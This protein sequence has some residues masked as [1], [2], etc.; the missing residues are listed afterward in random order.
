[1]SNA[2]LEYELLITAAKAMATI[3]QVE[4][5]AA[6][7]GK[8][9]PGDPFAGMNASAARAV[10]QLA[11]LDAR[12]RQLGKGGLTDDPFARLAASMQRAE[13]L[14]G[15]LGGG[16]GRVRWEMEQAARGASSLAATVGRPAFSVLTSSAT[17]ADTAL[18]AVERRMIGLA[19]FS[20]TV[21]LGGV[22]VG[23]AGAAAGTGAALGA[24]QSYTAFSAQVR[25]ASEN[26][27]QFEDNLRS[28]YRLAQETRTPVNELARAF[29]VFQGV[30]VGLDLP[31]D[32][33]E[34]LTGIVARLTAADMGTTGDRGSVLA[35]L[36][37]FI[38]SM[39]SQ[40]LQAGELNS[41]ADQN[42]QLARAILRAAQGT[43]LQVSNLRGVAGEAQA[44]RL[45]YGQFLQSFLRQ[46]Q[47]ADTVFRASPVSI[48]SSLEPIRNSLR[49]FFGQL[50]EQAG[51]STSMAALARGISERLDSA[52]SGERAG[53]RLR[54]SVERIAT[55][56]GEAVDRVLDELAPLWDETAAAA[57]TTGQTIGTQLLNVGNNA[58]RAISKVRDLARETAALIERIERAATQSDEGGRSWL[59]YGAAGLL[60]RFAATRL[61]VAGG[62]LGVA[63]AVGGGIGLYGADRMEEGGFNLFDP[64][65]RTRAVNAVRGAVG[66]APMGEGAPNAPR[67]P[68]VGAPAPSGDAAGWRAAS[69][70]SWR[71]RQDDLARQRAAAAGVPANSGRV[72]PGEGGL[73]TASPG[74]SPDRFL[75]RLASRESGGRTGARNQ[76]G[77]S[78][79]YQF[80]AERLTDLGLYQRAPGENLRS[81]SW[82]GT[83]N[84]PGFEG[85]RTRADFLQNADAQMVAAIK[86]L[87]DIDRVIDSTPGA[88]RFS[89]DGLRAVAHLGGI[90]GMQ[91]Y[92]R[93]QGREVSD[94]LGTS[95]RDYYERFSALERTG[96]GVRE[97][98]VRQLEVAREQLR[99]AQANGGPALG[100]TNP[101]RGAMTQPP[102][103]ANIEN[104][105]AQMRLQAEMMG[106][107]VE[108]SPYLRRAEE[109]RNATRPAEIQAEERRQREI[110]ADEF[111]RSS[112]IG[113]NPQQV[114]PQQQ[115]ELREAQLALLEAQA[116][117]GVVGEGFSRFT[118]GFERVNEINKD[119]REMAAETARLNAA[120]EASPYLRQAEAERARTKPPEVLAEERRQR[121][122]QARDY[123]Q[124]IRRGREPGTVDPEQQE[125]VYQSRLAL[126]EAQARSETVQA[127]AGAAAR[128]FEESAN[129][130]RGYR[131]EQE[132]L[133]RLLQAYA[134]GPEAGRQ[135]LEDYQDER[136]VRDVARDLPEPQAAAVRE[137]GRRIGAQDRRREATEQA[138]GMSR[139]FSTDTSDM[140]RQIAA[141]GQGEE[142]VA[143]LNVQLDVERRSREVLRNLSGP[144]RE[145]LQGQIDDYVK[146]RLEM[147][148]T[149]AQTAEFR[150]AF[151]SAADNIGQSLYDMATG[152]KSAGDGFRELRSSMSQMVFQELA[153][154]PFRSVLGDVGARISGSLSSSE[155][156]GFGGIAGQLV[157]SV[158]GW[159]GFGGGATPRASGGPVDAGV[160]WVGEHGPEPVVFSGSG[161]VVSSQEAR[162]AVSGGGGGRGGYGGMVSI[163]IQTPNPTSFRDS[164]GQIAAEVARLVGRGQAYG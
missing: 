134:R 58:E 88:E 16:L 63:A 100:V 34:K 82:Q 36:R 114:N 71:M 53:Q 40:N 29:N 7:V 46:E 18:A 76:W 70:R 38:Q 90:G 83:F 45:D 81:N 41:I 127:R 77:Y 31:E 69:D 93:G 139:E 104:Q 111:E 28:V 32:V 84:I 6:G 23:A 112:R 65:G 74:S 164:Q 102:R 12:F 43:G 33:G 129:L 10:A 140:R 51:V 78:G 120:V 117:S 121:E 99:Q 89:R 97:G 133:E 24:A 143:R 91:S 62:P 148:R 146:L 49:R 122:V 15:P 149:D 94:Q 96:G 85:V 87:E 2:R 107:L 158:G 20:A 79:L 37:Q 162:A 159:L 11:G 13:R 132:A 106:R 39:Q 147:E 26:T 55:G 161:R 151:Q 144:A 5:K 17:R 153:L 116:R 128:A 57:D 68:G 131:E 138:V 59:E 103:D 47:F 60:A 142:A 48:E 3:D 125:R 80:G 72:F 50:D 108:Q 136:R 54:E 73:P 119:L 1:M 145:A 4:K 52:F 56:A 22:A 126:L 130:S 67:P 109:E 30:A 75:S 154:K 141:Y 152:A 8:G 160:Y 115:Q 98:T 155:G 95:R 163:N 156:A 14:T 101:Q 25:L 118:S 21:V 113:R 44:G 9:I 123:E 157:N 137:T 27:T 124:Q 135:A 61:G 86:H 150:N 19:R 64:N 92:V 105:L 110:R 66:M 35:G 42:P